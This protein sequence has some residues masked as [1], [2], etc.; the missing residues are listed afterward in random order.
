MTTLS[1]I[2]IAM[3]FVLAREPMHRWTDGIWRPISVQKD[4]GPPNFDHSDMQILKARQFA[5][6]LPI[7]AIITDKGLEFLKQEHLTAGTEPDYRKWMPGI[8]KYGPGE[9]I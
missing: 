2:Q 1:E 7:G 4:P 9:R 5:E 8:P 6:M 3:L